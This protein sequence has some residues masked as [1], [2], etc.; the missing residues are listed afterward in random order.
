MAKNELKVGSSFSLTMK[1][2]E[3]M[4][5]HLV[6]RCDIRNLPLVVQSDE[7][8]DAI[9]EE[10]YPTEFFI[11]FPVKELTNPTIAIKADDECS[12]EWVV[13]D[14]FNLTMDLIWENPNVLWVVPDIS[15]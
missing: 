13:L 3:K 1:N 7:I 4:N 14:V 9:I 15:N 5:F 6:K 11:S 8:M 2:G 12:G 10:F